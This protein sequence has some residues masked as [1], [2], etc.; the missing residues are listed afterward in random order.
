MAWYWVWDIG[1]GE[2]AASGAES[3]DA[4]LMMMSDEK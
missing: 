2:A 1:D 4:I 3:D